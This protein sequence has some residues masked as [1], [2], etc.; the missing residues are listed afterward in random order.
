MKEPFS[1]TEQALSERNNRK[2]LTPQS[3][4]IAFSLLYKFQNGSCQL[5]QDPMQEIDHINGNPGDNAP[6]NLR[7]LS[8]AEHMRLHGKHPEYMDCVECANRFRS[9]GHG[10]RRRYCGR[11]CATHAQRRIAAQRRGHTYDTAVAADH[12]Q[13]SRCGTVKP[14]TAF[15][16]DKQRRNG[17]G[18]WCKACVRTYKRSRP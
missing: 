5:C 8:H 3:Y 15:S 9:N 12:W 4:K 18:T 13:C 6:D 14:F 2:R 1:A 17:R 7:V 11:G 16:R 10:G